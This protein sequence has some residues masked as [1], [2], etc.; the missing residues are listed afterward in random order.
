MTLWHPGSKISA[1]GRT[2]FITLAS[3]QTNYILLTFS[4]ELTTILNFRLRRTASGVHRSQSLEISHRRGG[5]PAV[6]VVQEAVLA[7]ISTG[8][9]RSPARV[10]LLKKDKSKTYQTRS[11]SLLPTQNV[12][13]G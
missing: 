2:T 13:V 1:S 6:S 10:N 5:Q 8:P 11:S 12:L 3:G 9:L 4:S 7:G